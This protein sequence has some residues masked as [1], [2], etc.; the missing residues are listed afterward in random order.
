M[1]SSGLACYTLRARQSLSQHPLGIAIASQ[2]SHGRTA[3]FLTA[4]RVSGGGRKGLCYV[5]AKFW[6]EAEKIVALLFF[7]YSFFSIPFTAGCQIFM[8][9]LYLLA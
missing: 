8:D 9:D 7:Q 4:A 3:L 6:D 5:N 2:Q 1:F